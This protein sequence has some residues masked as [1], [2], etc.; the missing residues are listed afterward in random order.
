MPTNIDADFLFPTPSAPPSVLSPYNWPGVSPGSTQALK[1]VL[2][3]NHERWHIFFNEKGFHNHASH[4]S[5][6]IWSLGADPAI[7][8]AGYK[9]DCGLQRPA[10]KSPEEITEENFAQ[11]LGDERFWDAYLNFFT[12]RVRKDGIDKTFETFIFS[13][14]YNIGKEEMLTRFMSGLVHP[15]I[16]TGYGAE[17]DIPGMVIEGLAQTC[18]HQADVS[19]ILPPSFFEPIPTAP[20]VTNGTH[21]DNVHALTILA[22]VAADSRLSLPKDLN[23]LALVQNIIDD[24]SDLIREYA[25]Q[26]T[27]DIQK[28][29]EIERKVEEITWMNVVMYGVA[30][31]TWAQQVKQGQE[32]EFN[33]DFFLAH[34]VTSVAFLPSLLGRLRHSPHSQVLLLRGYLA[35][36]LSWYI[37]RA[38]PGLDVEAFFKS[39]SATAYPL[40]IHTLPTPHEGALPGKGKIQAQVPDPWLPLVQSS[41]VHPDEHLPKAVRALAAWSGKF[42]TAPAGT[43]SGP[44]GKGGIRTELPGAEYLDGT[45]FIRVAGLTVARMGRVGQGEAPADFWD[46]L[47]FYLDPERAKEARKRMQAVIL[48]RASM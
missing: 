41:V 24:H 5:L 39:S 20:T 32:G 40:P 15:L 16:H 2:K 22:R 47:G 14:K 11:H 17:F 6:A 44:Q 37:A 38:R 13:K 43:F 19:K 36:V 33:A 29:G 27:I 34:L 31:W 12:D 9:T 48:E 26:W 21:G 30:G 3:D 1:E 23:E 7:I 28:P 4:R 25:S 42:G 45:L 46:R 10:Y 18:V 35:V 8:R